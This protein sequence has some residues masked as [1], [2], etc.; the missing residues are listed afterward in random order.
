MEDFYNNSS[1]SESKVSQ[2]TPRPQTLF[3]KI[4]ARHV[5]L[6]REQG[7]SLI[8][9][10]RHI[11]HDGSVHAFR[12]LRSKGLTV[13]KPLQ[14]FGVADHYIPTKSRFARDAGSPEAAEMFQSF[15]RNMEWAGVRPP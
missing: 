1:D 14:V 13:R 11:V 10:D 4:W 3:E 8:Y 7:P 9:I 2:T 12:Q 6:N 15:D 5:V